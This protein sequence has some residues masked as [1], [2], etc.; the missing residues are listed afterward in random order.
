V[1]PS[2]YGETP[3]AESVKMPKL[4]LFDILDHETTFGTT[5]LTQ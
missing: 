1:T 4:T 2:L 5:K 3:F